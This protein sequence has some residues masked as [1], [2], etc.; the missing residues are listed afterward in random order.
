MRRMEDK[1]LLSLIASLTALA[2][3]LVNVVSS[4][5]ASRRSHRQSQV[6][7]RF[8]SQVTLLADETRRSV[9]GL[10]S[11][12][13]AIQK[14]K[15]AIWMAAQAVPSSV[16]HVELVST[17]SESVQGVVAAFD[18]SDPFLTVE[19]RKP[20]HTAKNVA[21]VVREALVGIS[22]ISSLSEERRSLVLDV[23]NE[24]TVLQTELRGLKL[25]TLF[26]IGGAR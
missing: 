7:E 22:D 10:N 9:E 8:K 14:L 26:D 13:A 16:E 18:N 15:E 6:L 20:F 2:V 19:Q 5:I 4:V 12:I 21:L 17:I 25:E 1:I 23:R 11:G 3:S 24:L